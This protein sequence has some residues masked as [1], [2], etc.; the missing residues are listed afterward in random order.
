[1]PAR[2]ADLG[3]IVMVL[4]TYNEAANL[5][6]LVGRLRAVVPD[7]DVLVVDDASPDGTGAVA[8]LL[9]AQDPSVRV[10]LRA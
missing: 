10:V 5:P 4:P 6:W 2:F 8:D 9:A 1:M 7:V 3:R